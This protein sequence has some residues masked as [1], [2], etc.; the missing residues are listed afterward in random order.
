M[1]CRFKL[2]IPIVCLFACSSRQPSQNGTTDTNAKDTITIHPVK[3][4]FSEGRIIEK[5]VCK[6]DAS[7][8]YALYIP[9]VQN[10]AP[11][12]VIYCFDPHGDG[13]LPLRHYQLLADAYHFIL[14]GSNNSKNGN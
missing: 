2:F 8:S 6:N 11:M 10:A 1:T 5:V 13:S 7:Q 14:V 4:S 9:I 12:P 3:D